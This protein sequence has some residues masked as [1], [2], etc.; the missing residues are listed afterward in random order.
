M[1]TGGLIVGGCVGINGLGDVG[2]DGRLLEL[3]VRLVF[4][5]FRLFE[6]GVE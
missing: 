3:V 2:A 6:S 5:G 1:I 4:G